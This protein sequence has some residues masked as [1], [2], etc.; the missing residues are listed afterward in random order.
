VHG[1]YP[2]HNSQPSCRSATYAFTQ[3]RTSLCDVER[4]ALVVNEPQSSSYIYAHKVA[5]PSLADL[6]NLN[7]NA[8]TMFASIVG[9]PKCGYVRACCSPIIYKLRK[10]S[11]MC[12]L[13]HDDDLH[14]VI[15][16]VSRCARP[17]TTAG[18]Y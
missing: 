18:R 12:A 8:H 6:L 4:S 15:F 10:F 16:T 1:P 17:C 3:V 11:N 7:T 2:N 13:I 5:R 9:S 14:L